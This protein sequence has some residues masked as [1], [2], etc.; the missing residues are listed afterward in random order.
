M[1]DILSSKNYTFTEAEKIT[2]VLL[3]AELTGKNTMGLLKLMGSEPAQE[4]KPKYPPKIIK[5]T[6]LSALVDGG[7]AAGPLA[8]QVAVDRVIEV[9]KSNEFGIVGLNNTFSSICAL[10]YYAKKIADNNLIGIVAANSPKAIIY[11]DTKDPA[12]GTNPIAFSFPTNDC[13]IIFDA[14]SSAI[15]WYGLVRAKALGQQLPENIALDENGDPTTDPDKAM[16]GG[17]LPFDRGYKG[18][19]LA[20]VVELLTGPLTGASY[21]YLDGDWGSTFIAISPDLLVGTSEFK[22]NASD[23]VKKIKSLRPKNGKTIRVPG[24]DREE[25]LKDLNDDSEIEIEDEILSQIKK[26]LT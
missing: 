6:K 4:I 16:S 9:A 23:L 3:Y 19:G 2:E 20:M 22:K 7:G 10:S 15:T 18:A 14:A 17:I 11:P 8:A 5:E 21:V 24:F 1:I 26:T 25:A 13:P 12:F